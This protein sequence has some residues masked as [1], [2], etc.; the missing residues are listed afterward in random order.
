VAS[1][2]EEALEVIKKN[3]IDLLISDVRMPGIDGIELMN[4]VNLLSP[5]TLIILMT[6][7]A[8]VETAI[9]ALRS[10]AADYMLKPLDFDELVLRINAILERRNLV[11]ENRYMREVIDRSYNFNFII[12][13]SKVMKDLYRV[14]DKVGAS[15]STVLV[16]GPSGSGK[17]LIARALHQRSERKNKPFIAI[18]CGS[19]PEAL[20]ESELFGHKKGS[21]TGAVTDRD[22]HFMLANDGTLFLDEI[23]E[24][25]LAMQVK[26]LRVLQDGN[27][28]PVGAAKPVGVDVRIIAATN[29]NLEKEVEEGRFREDLFYRL[30][31]IRIT[32]PGLSQRPDD[33][34][35]LAHHFL[36]KHNRELRTSVKGISKEA[37]QLM[38]QHRWKGEVR[39]LQNVMERAVLLTESEY[40]KPED[41]PFA[42]SSDTTLDSTIDTVSGLNKDEHAPLND[43]VTSFEKQYIRHMLEKF[44]GNRSETARALQIDPSTLYRKM[45]KLG[46]AAE[47]Q[48]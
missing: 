46:I 25:P 27:V 1:N 42:A 40:I 28:T 34:P 41:L 10:G 7:F 48:S 22:G 18:N 6:A 21:F 19:I 36:Q 33:I 17:E 32:A 15:R 39:E 37:M 20:F 24:M 9:Q 11:R 45:E 5:E 2:G 8:S 29:R 3:D 26:L 31:I 44:D 13:E 12:G 47:E 30:N 38:M 43:V 14:I 16:T 4:E 35:L 23:G